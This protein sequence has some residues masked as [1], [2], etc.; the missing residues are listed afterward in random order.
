MNRTYYVYLLT[1]R[2]GTLYI[3]VTNCLQRRLLEHRN[4]DVDGF[5]TRYNIDQLIYFETFT[6]PMD[7]IRREKQL[8][9]WKREKKLALARLANPSLHELAVFSVP[10]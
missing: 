4:G 3:G 6:M 8:K 2:S 1:N 7:A 9:G 10:P 5:T